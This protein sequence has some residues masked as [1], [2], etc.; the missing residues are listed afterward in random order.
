MAKIKQDGRLLE[1]TTP[2]KKNFLLIKRLSCSEGLNQLFHIDLEILHEE[3]SP[4]VLPTVVEPNDVLGKPFTISVKQKNDKERY[5]NGICILFSQGRRNENFSSYRAEVVPKVWLL[6][7]IS[8]SRIFQNKTVPQILE[9]VLKGFEYDLE[10]QGNFKPRNYCVQYRE[11]DWN[12]ASRLMEEEGIYYYFE[13]TDGSHKLVIG[14]T[15]ESHRNCPSEFKIPYKVDTSGISDTWAHQITSWQVDDRLLTGKYQLRDFNF[16]LPLNNLQADQASCFN[17]GGNQKLEVYDWHGGYAKRFDGI[18]RGGGENPPGLQPIF[19]D[20]ER[21]V[22]IR[23]EELDVNYKHIFATSDCCTLTAGY[24]FKLMRHPVKSNNINYVIVSAQHEAVQSPGYVSDELDSNTYSVSFLTIPHGGGFAPYRPPR[25]T[26][27]PVVRGT[28]TAKVVGNPGDEI[29]TDKYGRIKVQFHWDRQGKNDAD[30][31][32]WIRVGTL[33][34]G[35]QWG[36]IHIP[37]VGQEVIVDFIEGDPDHPICVGSVYNPETMPPYTLP[38][39]KTQSGVKSRSSLGGGSDN[40]NEFRFEDLKGSEE[41]Y[42]HAE[43]DWTIMV[44]ND[45]NQI[46]G[47]N[48]TLL[49][50]NDRTK[51]VDHDETTT[52]KNDR[53]ETVGNNETITIVNN[54]TETVQ[55]NESIT[56]AKDRTESVGVNETITIGANRSRSVGGNHDTTVMGNENNAVSNDRS[57]NIGKRF[58]LAATTSIEESSNEIT[59]TARTKLTLAGPGGTIVIDGRGITINGVLVKIN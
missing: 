57:D 31:S 37:R 54:R 59:I 25:L 4:G 2:L 30:S 36:V 10:I 7:Q 56:I 53:T 28:Q 42:L 3:D 47:H 27:R 6:T 41:V 21:T 43:K 15:R 38:A 20:R 58:S 35:K 49:V 45:K 50:K 46:V 5:F 44:E 8:Q 55:Q 32:C 17:V 52:V 23:Q 11:S 16:Q 1:L 40:F 22:K 14:N 19:D 51:T 39:N 34:A 48:E 29:F 12:F 24:R 13:H 18:D 9:E 26:S 33:W